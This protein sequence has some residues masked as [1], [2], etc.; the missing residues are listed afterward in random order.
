MEGP[1]ILAFEN[2]GDFGS[3]LWDGLLPAMLKFAIPFICVI[4][5]RDGP[6]M[7]VPPA[8]YG[9]EILDAMQANMIHVVDVESID[10]AV[11][12]GVAAEVFGEGADPAV[13]KA[14]ADYALATSKGVSFYLRVIVRLLLFHLAPPPPTHT[15]CIHTPRHSL[16]SCR[17]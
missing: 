5:T 11:A 9:L 14:A 6:T 12:E 10:G 8:P 4:V 17:T 3:I 16:N 2:A 1:T 13:V 15:Q 7:S